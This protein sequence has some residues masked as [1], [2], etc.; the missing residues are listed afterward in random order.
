MRKITQRT[1]KSK[2]KESPK[3]VGKQLELNLSNARND[4]WDSLTPYEPSRYQGITLDRLV[5]VG[6]NRLVS[7]RIENTFDNIVVVLHRLFPDKFSL[8]SFPQYPDFI[9]VDNTL[10][11]DCRHSRYVIGSRPRGFSLTEVGRIAAEDTLKLIETGGRMGV[12]AEPTG[13]RRHR[14]TLLIKEA[15]NSDAF[16]KYKSGQ[17]LS[18]FDVCDFLHGSLDTEEAAL[19]QNL[20]TLQT[21]TKMLLPI[22]EYRDLANT[23]LE[24][25]DFLAHHWGEL[26]HE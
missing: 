20:D 11:L 17:T 26:M 18:K 12:P 24:F 22:H 16:R 9:R 13:E 23:V 7:A 15:R 21:Y 25:L 4:F 2:C 6:I 19:K 8:I 3:L 10:R 14:A 1:T 5:A